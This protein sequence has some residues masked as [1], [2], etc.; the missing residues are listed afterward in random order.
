MVIHRKTLPVTDAPASCPRPPVQLDG[1]L[2]RMA[3]RLLYIAWFRRHTPMR[4]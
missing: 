3:Y 4:G 2:K 1:R